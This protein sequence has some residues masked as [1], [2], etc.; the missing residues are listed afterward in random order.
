M[1][2][3]INKYIDR[4]TFYYIALHSIASEIPVEIPIRDS[5]SILLNVIK[6]Y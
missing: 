4:Y 1:Y 3:D 6:C 2:K 5:Y